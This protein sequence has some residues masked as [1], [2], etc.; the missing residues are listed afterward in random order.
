M[1]VTFLQIQGRIWYVD[2][3]VAVI[4]LWGSPITWGVAESLPRIWTAL[5]PQQNLAVG[6]AF[7][8]D[9][10]NFQQFLHCITCHTVQNLF[11]FLT[12]PNSSQ[13]TKISDTESFHR[14]WIC[15]TVSA[16]THFGRQDVTCLPP[17]NSGA[18]HFRA[19]HF[20]DSENSGA[21]HFAITQLFDGPDSEFNY[22]LRS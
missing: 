7:A 18:D 8:A 11:L 19:T 5:K 1:L 4:R 21:Y 3:N 2:S 20:A 9:P 15:L 14:I 17:H 12:L 22:Q 6:A 13:W 10:P 16:E